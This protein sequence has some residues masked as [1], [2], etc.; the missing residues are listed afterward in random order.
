MDPTR[1]SLSLES[2]AV[3]IKQFIANPQKWLER[4]RK[5]LQGPLP[6]K[7]TITTSQNGI[8]KARH[9]P[10]SHE[11]IIKATPRKST[12]D[13]DFHSL[14][15]FCPPVASLLKPSSLK[16]NWQRN[17][18]INLQNDPNA[19]LLHAD[20]ILVAAQLRLDCAT[21]LTSKRRIFLKKIDTLKIDREFR[22]TDAQKACNID[23]NKA[24]Q[25][26]EAFNKVGW[27]D[28][29]WFQNHI[30]NT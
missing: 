25:L 8:V 13:N 19:H 22:K 29:G 1:P 28:P 24:S 10:R 14:P 30:D 12:R 15:D 26:W 4:E 17:R 20:E 9:P 27:F 2:K 16:V 18:P 11:T 23:V 6:T 7:T 5:F 21:Y 3:V